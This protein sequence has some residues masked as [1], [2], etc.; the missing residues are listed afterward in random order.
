MAPAGRKRRLCIEDTA[1]RCRYFDR[2]DGPL[3]VRDI[4]QRQRFDRVQNHRIRIAERHVDAGPDAPSC[5]LE[6]NLDA[7]DH[8]INLHGE[9]D[10]TIKT[11]NLDLVGVAAIL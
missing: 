8:H 3:I 5:S 6:I 2:R 11:F 9:I 1:H 10:G 4:W 7:V